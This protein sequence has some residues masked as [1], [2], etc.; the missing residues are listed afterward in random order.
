LTVA[1]LR[2]SD[3]NSGT[4]RADHDENI[5]AAMELRRQ[6]PGWVVVWSVPLQRF[7]AGPLFRAQRG[8]DLTAQTI[9]ELA[10]LMDQAE[11]AAPGPPSR[12]PCT[13]VWQ[14]RCVAIGTSGLR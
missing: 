12:S 3:T 14:P 4:P 13:D 1:S 7:S 10:A 9:T 6:R 2:V 8:T 5:Q 11:Q